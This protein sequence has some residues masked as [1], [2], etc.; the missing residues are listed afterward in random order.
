[1]AF[2]PTK[3]VQTRDGR[4]ARIIC[5]DAKGEQPIAA[6]VLECAQEM[7]GLHSSNGAWLPGNSGPHERDLINVPQKREGWIN[8]YPA[9]RLDPSERRVANTSH[10]YDTQEEAG[11]CA[12]GNRI[13]CVKVEWEEP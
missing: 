5:T 13:A 7:L 9:P 11:R 12:F 8:I 4:P 2:G 3:P 1:M 10:A 6:L